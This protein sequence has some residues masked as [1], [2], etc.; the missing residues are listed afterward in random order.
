MDAGVGYGGLQQ[1]SGPYGDAGAGDASTNYSG[2]QNPPSPYSQTTGG[3]STITS[4]LGNGVNL[5]PSYY[6]ASGDLGNVDLGW[7]LMKQCPNIKS[8]R[9]EI[10]GNQVAN[11]KRWIKEAATNGYA[12]IAT[13]HKSSILGDE[14]K[15]GDPNEL[16]QAAEWWEVNYPDL[17]KAGPLA[18]NLMNEWGGHKISAPDF[19]AAYNQAIS[20]VRNVYAGPIVVDIPGY[21]QGVRVASLAAR[22][23]TDRNLILSTHIYPITFNAGVSRAMSPGDLDELASTNLGCIV[24]ELG[25]DGKGDV[26]QRANFAALVAKVQSNG[27]PIFG[28]AWNGDNSP[29]KKMNMIQPQ[30]HSGADEKTTPYTV[31]NPYF[32]DI[33]KLL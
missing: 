16:L 23:I 20:M 30:F 22:S 17:S 1:P 5:Q 19:A 14:S 15:L 33:C 4:G 24:G 12:I 31:N 32:T 29:G 9:I 25:D 18:I 27:W 7:G 10:E 8:V 2:A 11:A 13:F 28:W 21:G 26:G 3:H 6:G